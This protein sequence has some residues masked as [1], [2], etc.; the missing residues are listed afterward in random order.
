MIPAPDPDLARLQALFSRAMR[1]EASREELCDAFVTRGDLRGDQ[2]AMIYRN[3]YWYRLVDALWEDLPHVRSV[4]GDQAF[5]AT[6]TAYLRACPSIHPTLEQLGARFAAYLRTCTEAPALGDEPLASL[7]GLAD[8]EWSHSTAFLAVAPARAMQMAD[9]DARAFPEQ[10]A[11]F[12]PSLRV[13]AAERGVL[14]VWD[15]PTPASFLARDKTPTTIATWRKGFDVFHQELSAVEAAA[16]A[17]AT[18]GG[19]MADVCDPFSSVDDTG[20]LTAK[21]LSAWFSRQWIVTLA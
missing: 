7:A 4:L 21:T 6:V 11:T 13:V 18:Q 2:R 20:A 3:M 5:A 12:S 17:I 8:L 9:I 15:E 19:T 1:D 10:R 14:T 16:L